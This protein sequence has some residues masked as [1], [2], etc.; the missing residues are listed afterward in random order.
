MKYLTLIFLFIVDVIQ[1]FVTQNFM[2]QLVGSLSTDIQN[3][4]SN[5]VQ[6]KIAI[7]IVFLII[8]L[9]SFIIFWLPFLNGL[10]YQIY[11]TKLMLMIIPLEVL[12][13]IKN[14]GKVL[15]S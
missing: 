5:R 12:M 10:N 15:Q 13:K 14:V 6:T 11:K 8:V 4:F 9:I 1:Y 3:D 2:R 7:F